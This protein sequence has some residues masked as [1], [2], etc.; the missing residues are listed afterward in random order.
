M[1]PLNALF[2]CLLAPSALSQ[3]PCSLSAAPCPVISSQEYSRVFEQLSTAVGTNQTYVFSRLP[4]SQFPIH[5]FRNGL[6]LDPG[7]DFDVNGLALK[8]TPKDMT[9]ASDVL[10][11]AYTSVVLG[12][13]GAPGVKTRALSNEAEDVLTTYLNRAL[14][15]EL[16]YE[17]QTG[18][19]KL[20]NIRR[21]PL[22]LATTNLPVSTPEPNGIASRRTLREQLPASLRMLS[23]ALN[24]SSQTRVAARSDIHTSRR[25]K[26]VGLESI[27]D[28]SVSAPYSLFANDPSGLNAM[29]DGIDVA[30]RN[31]TRSLAD[32]APRGRDP[33]SLRMLGAR[34][35]SQGK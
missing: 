19:R 30:N 35:G 8:L 10:T 2:L 17:N 31:G 34:L 20:H 27:G 22:D 6:E 5:V 24:Q 26:E 21:P 25:T 15:S 12:P 32:Q 13:T 1:R 4:S 14:Q 9:A 16:G 29:L 11:A 3:T 28:G 23:V 7:T 33:A 18:M